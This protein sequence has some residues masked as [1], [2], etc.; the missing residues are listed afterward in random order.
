MKKNY[1]LIRIAQAT[2]GLE[3]EPVEGLYGVT[4]KHKTSENLR[5]QFV[6]Q[7]FMRPEF[8]VGSMWSG[9]K[10]SYFWKDMT[11][12]QLEEWNIASRR[13]RV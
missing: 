4:W 2:N 6:A 9:L 7:D 11:E 12:D 5:H 8:V 1:E 13:A 10:I 3:R